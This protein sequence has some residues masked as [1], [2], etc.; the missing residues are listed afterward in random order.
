MWGEVSLFPSV[1]DQ[2]CPVV[3]LG[4]THL[5]D[6]DNR[7]FATYISVDVKI[8]HE[9]L[10]VGT[11][12]H[13]Q[14]PTA[15][16]LAQISAKPVNDCALPSHRCCVGNGQRSL[17]RAENDHESCED[18]NQSDSNRRRLI[19]F[20]HLDPKPLQI[21]AHPPCEN[22]G[23]HHLQELRYI[24]LKFCKQN[25]PRSTMDLGSEVVETPSVYLP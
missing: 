24:I 23:P 10:W 21:H 20:R 4:T 15:T 16:D 19:Y 5:D 6:D 2:D 12:S 8:F 18:G 22:Y 9:E 13:S 1:F 17:A 7:R 14:V 25:L 11:I 3:P